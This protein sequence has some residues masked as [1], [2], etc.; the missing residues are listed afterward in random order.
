M[1]GTRLRHRTPFSFYL[2]FANAVGTRFFH[3]L[4]DHFHFSVSELR[5]YIQALFS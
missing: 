1:T 2:R 4:F 3:M 5:V